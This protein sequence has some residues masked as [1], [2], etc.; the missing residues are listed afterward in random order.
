ML[1]LIVSAALPPPA[2]R[3]AVQA[4]ATVRIARPATGSEKE[5]KAMPEASRR[6]RIIKDVRGEPLL[7]RVVDYE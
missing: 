7:L 6:E 4:S 2:P 5:W 1:L 3:V